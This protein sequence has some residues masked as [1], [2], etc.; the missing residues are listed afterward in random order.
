[1]WPISAPRS[2][3]CGASAGAAASSL[4]WKS[5]ARAIRCSGW[6]TK[7]ISSG[8]CR[9]SPRCWAAIQPPIPTCRSRRA[10]FR[11]P[12]HW[13]VSCRKLAGAMFATRCVVWVLS[14]FTWR[15][16]D[17]TERTLMARYDDYDDRRRRRDE[18]DDPDD[19]SR[20]PDDRSPAQRDTLMQRR[21]RRARGE[22]IDDDD[23]Y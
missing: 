1:M 9:A 15:S 6:G 3:R 16:S 20:R 5:P 11:R 8:L 14:P 7:S 12:I 13:H 2:A 18:D 23:Y 22:E 17:E 10:P 4:A 19:Y 21:L